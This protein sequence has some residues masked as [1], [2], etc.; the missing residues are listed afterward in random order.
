MNRTLY[1]R[2]RVALWGG[3]LLLLLLPAFVS[4]G[5]WQWHKAQAKLA[6]QAELDLLGQ[7]APAAMPTGLAGANSLRHRRFSLQGEYDASRQILIDNRVYQERAG[8]H[9][10]TPLKLAG[11][12]LRV[13]VNR[14]WV[15]APADHRQVPDMPPPAGPVSITGIA[16]VPPE[17]F[18]TLAPAPAGEKVWQNLDLQRFRAGVPYPL[19]PVVLQLDPGIPG[20]YGRDWPRPDEGSD[21]NLGYAAQWFGFAI[22]SLGI[23]LY[24]LVRRP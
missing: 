12:E 11:S 1:S 19:Q 9:V 21:R 6:R 7:G 3:L 16:V 22:A 2:R 13:L 5:L 17:R 15:P 4:L 23:W 20:G 10:V 8:Y 14:G 24:F 18:F